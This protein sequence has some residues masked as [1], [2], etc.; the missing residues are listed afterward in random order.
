MDESLKDPHNRPS[1][2]DAYL[3]KSTNVNERQERDRRGGGGICISKTAFDQI[4]TRLLL[5]Y[6]Y[7][8]EQQ[9]KNIAKP[10]GAYRVRM[11]RVTVR[12]RNVHFMDLA[13][14]IEYLRAR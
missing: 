4:E 5:G 6:E 10:V 8:G 1:E 13:P 7:L 9:V 2:N 14:R 12:E 11:E 3:F